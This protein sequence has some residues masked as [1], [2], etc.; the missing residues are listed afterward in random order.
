MHNPV[1][2]AGSRMYQRQLSAAV[3]HVNDLWIEEGRI[4][5][6]HVTSSFSSRFQPWIK[7]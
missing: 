4:G 2:V 6:S 7:L 1:W 3:N 5:P